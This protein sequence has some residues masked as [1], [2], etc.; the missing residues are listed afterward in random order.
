MNAFPTSSPRAPRLAAL[1]TLAWPF[2]MLAVNG[3]GTGLAFSINRLAAEA[4]VPFIAYVF[5]AALFAGVALLLFGLVLGTLPPLTLRHL[6][7]YV[8]MGA[9]GV[10]VPMT[11]FAFV[12]PRIPASVLSLGLI[13]TPMITYAL[14]LPLGLE[15]FRVRSLAGIALGI[16]GVLLVVVPESSLPERSMVGWVLVSLIG[17]TCFAVSNVCAAALR[18]PQTPSLVMGATMPLFAAIFLLAAMTAEGRWWFFDAGLDLGGAMVLVIAALFALLFFFMFEMV[19]LKGPVFF[20]SVN[21]IA[22]IAGIVFAMIIFGESLSPWL[23]A[24]LALMFA[25]LA[26]L[27]CSLPARAHRA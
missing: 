7:V 11:V 14:A 6:R 26:T 24:A 2:V 10:A 21:Y 22:P 8:V 5:W 27:H 13:L 19:R 3:V 9:T 15:R 1:A 4:G 23:W 17:P 20:S 25:G 16:A 18:P 12:A